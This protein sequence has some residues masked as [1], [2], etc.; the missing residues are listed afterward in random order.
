MIGA[1]AVTTSAT[2]VVPLSMT[3]IASQVCSRDSWVPVTGSIRIS[4]SAL[5]ALNE[6]PYPARAACRR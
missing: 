6:N 1:T 2:K 4:L 5:A 3:M